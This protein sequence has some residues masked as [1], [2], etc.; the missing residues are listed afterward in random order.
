MLEL[1]NS[2][3]HAKEEFSPLEE[4]VVRFYTCGPTVYDYAHIGNFRTFVFQDLLR[5]YLRYRGYRV[6]HVMNITDVDDKTIQ[7][8]REQ[9]VSLKDYTARY[10]EAFLE[11]SRI[12]KIEPPDI[13]PRATEHIGDMVRLIRT[14]EDK[15]YTYRKD[16]S[17]YFDIS[18]FQE[19]GKLSRADF[20]G[21]RSGTRVDADKYD[22]EN[23]RDFVLWKAPK[24]G[25]DFWETEIGPGRPGWHIECSA[26]SMRY[27]GETFDIHCGGADLIFP[28]HEN[29]IA[30][31]ECATGKPFVRYWIHPEFLIVEGEKMSKSLGNF[32]TLRDLLA[33]GHSPESI[34]YLLLSV[35]YRKQLNFTSDGLKQ[36]Q[37]S[38][39]RLED[40]LVHAQEI[41]GPGDPSADFREEVDRARKQFVE[42]MDD[43]L[44]TSAALAA[45]FE[46]TRSW[47]RQDGQ[48]SLS[49]GDG[50]I[51]VEFIQEVDRVFDILAPQEKELLDSEI[52]EQ[53]EVRE[54]ARR[55]RNFAEAD[56][57]RDL[58]A[59]RGIQLEDTRDGVRWKKIRP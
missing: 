55:N 22:K 50:R 24:E 3:T 36:A 42:A 7:N 8:A 27:L 25:E 26:M 20:S 52:A 23:A 59:A 56:R 9:G 38:I 15:G 46:C 1:Y 35:H 6:L 43:D 31:S 16:G 45:L 37:A 21:A 10:T 28:H 49:A 14:L 30:Q 11:D 57:I 44:N 18:R 48:N 53:I 34:R 33:E 58:L 2:L 13:M 29:E 41:A 51:A 54:A 19:Y 40:F 17:V 12:L 4:G 47:Y 5:R 32:H 39:R